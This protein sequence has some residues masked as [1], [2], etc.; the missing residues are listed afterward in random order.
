MSLEDCYERRQLRTS[1]PDPLKAKMSI[2]T[3]ESHL[4]EAERLAK[5]GFRNV[6][7][8]VAYASMF[9]AGR[10][11]LFKDGVIEKSHYCLAVYLREKYV[12]GGKLSN[13]LISVMD[14]F[15]EERQDVMYGLETPE[16]NKDDENAAIEN[17]RK[18]I[19]EVKKLLV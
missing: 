1:R 4:T 14:A 3:A 11:L 8:V 10:A 12:T 16:L 2:S 9:H 19:K 15:R 5:A 17:A 7:V 18:M 13:E 6:A